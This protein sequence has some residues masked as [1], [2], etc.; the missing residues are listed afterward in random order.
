MPERDHLQCDP[1]SIQ[2]KNG[3]GGVNLIYG[4]PIELESVTPSKVRWI[5]LFHNSYCVH[6]LAFKYQNHLMSWCTNVLKFQL[7]VT[8]LLRNYIIDIKSEP[9]SD[10]KP[11]EFFRPGNTR[12]C[13]FSDNVDEVAPWQNISKSVPLKNEIEENSQQFSNGKS[14][15]F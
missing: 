14:T 13:I 5:L 15:I 7:C 12:T 1:T 8:I 4:K 2:T 6:N 11:F 10:T 3:R 9:Q